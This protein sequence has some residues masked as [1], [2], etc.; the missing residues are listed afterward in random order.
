MKRIWEYKTKDIAKYCKDMHFRLQGNSFVWIITGKTYY[1]FLYLTPENKPDIND[2][3]YSWKINQK[4]HGC[5]KEDI[6][7]LEQH[8]DTIF[9]LPIKNPKSRISLL[10]IE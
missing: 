5:N 6:L 7:L 10:D 9:N 8:L 3:T 1:D 2:T 4:K